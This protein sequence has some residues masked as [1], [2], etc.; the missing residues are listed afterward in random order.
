MKAVMLFG[1]L[2]VCANF[3]PALATTF[4]VTN[5]NDSGPG[6]L[7]Q[8]ILDSRADLFGPH[9]INF[10]ITSFSTKTRVRTI[11]PLSPLPTISIPL[12]LD[13]TAQPGYAGKP[14][15][16]IEGSHAGAGAGLLISAGFST[17]KGLVINRFNGTGISMFDTNG[18]TIEGNYIGTDVTGRID[19]GN[20]GDGIA[21]SAFIG[22]HMIRGNVIS[23]NGGNGISLSLGQQ[24]FIED[25]FIGTDAAGSFALG[26]DLNGIRGPEGTIT[27]RRNVISGNG[28]NG[29]LSFG[30]NLFQGNFIG[31]DATGRLPIGNAGDGLRASFDQVGGLNAG[32]GNTIAFNGGSGVVVTRVVSVPTPILSNSIFA[33]GGM[34]IDIDDDGVTA[35]DACDVDSSSLALQN[36][37]VLTSVSRTNDHTVIEGTLDS[38]P[39]SVF[40]IQF[41]SNADCDPLGFGEGERLIGSL[42]VTSGASCVTS[43]AA[44]FP[45][46]SVPGAFI[47]ATA[48]ES[49]NSTS[50][51]SQCVAVTNPGAQ[52]A[53]QI[54]LNQVA[55]LVAQEALSQGQANGLSS[56]LQAA[57]Q[58][59]ERG[60]Q[61]PAAK[62]INAFIK[63]VEALIRSKILSPQQGQPLID[64][65]L[66]IAR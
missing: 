14:I 18:N 64:A 27:A 15:I 23:G 52:Q 24:N 26:N 6:S 54:L 19:L 13:G 8:A 25:N 57:L 65:A 46:A 48:T 39:N 17:I 49:G 4:T 20:S 63:Q 3:A 16:E 40:T 2:S 10:N 59:L 35:N 55:S 21:S 56:K 51:F 45:N 28:Q 5:V 1:F 61:R 43:F 50:E 62:Q 29:I 53:I 66:S 12:T 44:T 31:T 11:S 60:K 47:T 58:Q 9:V 7:R 34:G 22:D 30:E 37:P 32:E 41:F 38:K 33:N 42:T 36:F